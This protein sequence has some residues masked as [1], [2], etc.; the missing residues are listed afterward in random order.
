MRPKLSRQLSEEKFLQHYWLKSELTLFCRELGLAVQGSKQQLTER[1][2]DRLAGRPQKTPKTK[3]RGLQSKSSLPC[4]LTLRTRIGTGWTCSQ[5]LREFFV[6][7]CGK[8]FRFNQSV[9][10]FLVQGVGKTLGQAIEVYRASLRTG[11]KPIAS[12]FEYNR[13]IR[14]YKLDHPGATHAQAVS[15]WWKKRGVKRGVKQQEL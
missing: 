14:Q 11:P 12:Q 1:I 5:R 3:T 9:R 7:H 8:G 15:A 6:S 10:T 13:H 4:K 2:A